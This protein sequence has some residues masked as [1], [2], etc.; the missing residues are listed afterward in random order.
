M[1][2]FTE[3]KNWKVCK[4]ENRWIRLYAAPQL[5]G[6]LI[7]LEMNGHEF[8]FVN[9]LLA[10]K[11]PGPTRIG[12]NGEWMNFG[13]EKIWPA[14]QGWDSSDQWPGPPDPILDSGEYTTELDENN[15]SWLKLT[16]PIDKYTDLQV[17]K[18]V[19]VSKSRAEVIITIIF[20]NIGNTLK[21]WS[22]W[23]VL[24]MDTPTDRE[25]QY[26][27]LCPAN[28]ESRF[29]NGYKVM[30]GLVNNPQ[31]SL[32]EHG[33]IQVNYHYL[34]GKIGMDTNAGW[35]AFNDKTTGKVF[36]VMFPYEKDKIY[37][38]NTSFQVWTAGRGMV[39]SRNGI[40][41]HADDEVQNP[42]YMEMELLSPLQEIVPGGNVQFEYRMLVSTIPIGKT[43]KS[44]NKIGVVASSF[45][46]TPQ[47]TGI[48]IKATYGVFTEGTLKI[49]KRDISGKSAPVCLYEI[50]VCPTQGINIEI[51]IARELLSDNF[52]VTAEFFN[53]DNNVTG[54]LDEKI[55]PFIL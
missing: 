17:I 13:G 49:H 6:R 25:D 11:E 44:V 12:E 9:P 7:Q 46:S 38:D 29:V 45:T 47:E 20:K 52:S 10:G 8:F 50:N 53:F 16:S 37:P 51:I 41:Q 33:N 32:N 55:F 24:Q 36:I 34:A 22:I 2:V 54:I 42:P 23:P 27:I 1:P 15:R 35:A 39:Y 5:G 21:Y 28:P 40:H 19:S 14:P 18:E 30:H 3:Y 26:Q 4:L 43:V 48:L 31:Y